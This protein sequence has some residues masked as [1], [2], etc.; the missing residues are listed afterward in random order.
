[1]ETW[2]YLLRDKLGLSHENMEEPE[3]HADVKKAYDTFLAS[4]NM[5]DI[6]DICQKCYALALVSEEE[7]IAPVSILFV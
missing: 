1:M 4:S 6:I 2:K 7:S 5:L 3:N